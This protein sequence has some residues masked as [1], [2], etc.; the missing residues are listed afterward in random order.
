MTTPETPRRSPY[1][2]Y[3]V[4]LPPAKD[5]SAWG[6]IACLAWYFLVVF[7]GVFWFAWTF[8]RP[9]WQPA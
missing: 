4:P 8:V 5:R 6:R 2:N 9:L 1:E 7:A 3:Q